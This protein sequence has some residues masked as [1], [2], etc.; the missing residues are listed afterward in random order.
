MKHPLSGFA[1]AW[2]LLV[3]LV[4]YMRGYVLVLLELVYSFQCYPNG[5][6]FMAAS[7]VTFND[8]DS[9]RLEQVRCSQR[10]LSLFCLFDVSHGLAP[11]SRKFV[12]RR[13]ELSLSICGISKPNKLTSAYTALGFL[14]VLAFE[15]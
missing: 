5:T 9:V 7:H 6:F 14:N 10:F 4:F 8:L 3:K 2:I 11:R 1:A 15:L 13:S 12:H